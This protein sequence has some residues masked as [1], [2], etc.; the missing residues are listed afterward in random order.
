MSPKYVQ[1]THYCVPETNLARVTVL[2]ESQSV[3]L[4]RQSIV[5]YAP[6]GLLQ[7]LPEAAPGAYSAVSALTALL[8]PGS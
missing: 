4:R 8:L 5:L 3:P 7:P 6:T 2:T 1:I